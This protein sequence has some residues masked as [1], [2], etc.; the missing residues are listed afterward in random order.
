MNNMEGSED[1]MMLSEE[2]DVPM[3]PC[4]DKCMPGLDPVSD[5]G[6]DSSYGTSPGLPPQEHPLIQKKRVSWARIHTREFAL[7]VGDHP[8]C[9]DGLPVA[10]DW[11]HVDDAQPAP[12]I[13]GQAAAPV[14]ERKHS[15]VFPKRL[16]YQERRQRLCNVSGLTDDQVK[17]DE[18]DLVVRTLKESWESVEED[19]SSPTFDPTPLA[20]DDTNMMSVWEDIISQDADIDLGDISD[21]EWT[22]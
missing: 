5:E 7:V 19:G 12:N 1:V 11:Q 10:L 8:L 18:I 4:H 16:S 14:S 6:E 17:N 2:D 21:F 15:Y 9:Q 20:E 22:D 13:V 3:V